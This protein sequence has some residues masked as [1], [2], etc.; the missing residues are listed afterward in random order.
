MAES[1]LVVELAVVV[2]WG[3][4]RTHDSQT[5]LEYSFSTYQQR[6]GAA[7]RMYVEVGFDAGVAVQGEPP[8]A[9]AIAG[10]AEQKVAA[11]SYIGKVALHA[12]AEACEKVVL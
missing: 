12:G 9:E 7:V 2:W 8:F 1:T 3:V 5:R 10:M 6:V 11:G 4:V